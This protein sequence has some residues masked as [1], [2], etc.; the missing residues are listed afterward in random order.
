LN[1]KLAQFYFSTVC[2]GLEG[3]GTIYLRFFGQYIEKFPV[4]CIDFTNPADKYRHDR[5]VALVSEMLGLQKDRFE[6]ETSFDS[7]KKH[8]LD[9]RIAAVDV[10]IDH[11]VYDLYDLTEEEIKIVEGA[12]G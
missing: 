5:I 10:E 11:L 7:E 12:G 1:S 9:R 2:A 8:T 4:R 3:G 6:A